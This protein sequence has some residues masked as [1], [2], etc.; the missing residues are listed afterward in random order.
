M[1]RLRH[2]PRYLAAIEYRLDK[3]RGNLARDRQNTEEVSRFEDRYLALG[4]A[5]GEEFDDYRWM[6]E[7][8]RVSLFAQPLGT[9][10]PVSAK[11]LERLWQD[12]A[13]KS[14]EAG[15]R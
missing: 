5:P 9:T 7:E 3:L 13:V 14:R 11:R 4:E 6:L 2:F 1:A 12:T 15:Q 8:F 10:Q